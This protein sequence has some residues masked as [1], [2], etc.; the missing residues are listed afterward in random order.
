MVA[1]ACR[2]QSS[3]SSGGRRIHQNNALEVL[4]RRWTNENSILELPMKRWID[5]NSVLQ[6]LW[7]PWIDENTFLELLRRR[8]IDEDSIL[9]SR[10]RSPGGAG[11]T[12]IIVLASPPR[13]TTPNA[14]ASNTYPDPPKTTFSNDSE[15]FRIE[16]C[17]FFR[18]G[19]C[20]L[21]NVRIVGIVKTIASTR[22][23]AQGLGG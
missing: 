15:F 18:I 9:G 10:G 20:L 7:T 12:K 6:V 1:V 13:V 21:M 2:N 5:E 14:V 8:W 19:N 23:E 17:Q 16:N 4:R 11:I 3:G 22:P